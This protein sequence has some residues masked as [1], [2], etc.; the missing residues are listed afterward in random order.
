MIC[1]AP[2]RNAF[3]GGVDPAVMHERRQPRRQG[4]ERDVA[5]GEHGDGVRA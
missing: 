5:G 4:F 1:D 3:A 2:A